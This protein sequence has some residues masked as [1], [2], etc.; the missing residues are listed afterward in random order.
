MYRRY[1]YTILSA[2]PTYPVSALHSVF[3]IQPMHPTGRPLRPSSSQSTEFQPNPNQI[4]QQG[5]S[6]TPGY[7]TEVSTFR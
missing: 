3:C 2:F 1:E 6:K 5:S 7:L 4:L